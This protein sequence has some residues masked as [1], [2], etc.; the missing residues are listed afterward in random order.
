MAI[1]VAEE[2]EELL[3]VFVVAAASSVYKPVDHHLLV[4]AHTTFNRKSNEKHKKMQ[5]TVNRKLYRVEIC[6]R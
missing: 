4:L 5:L 6:P 3:V 1:F 2:L